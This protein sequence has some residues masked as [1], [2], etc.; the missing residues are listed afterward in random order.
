MPETFF[1][2]HQIRTNHELQSR[3]H[4]SGGKWINQYIAELPDGWLR[5]ILSVEPVDAKRDWMH[6]SVS[7]CGQLSGKSTRLA[8]DDE[9]TLVMAQLR[10]FIEWKG[11][12]VADD[13]PDP[14]QD[15]TDK[16]VRHFWNPKWK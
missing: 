8:T 12:F 15:R 9:C 4:K 5:V 6:V 16:L 10:E 11:E 13:H 7:V 14:E 1:E 2:L 3:H